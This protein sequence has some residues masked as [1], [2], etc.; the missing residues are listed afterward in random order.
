M[1][2]AFENSDVCVVMVA[3]DEFKKEEFMIKCSEKM[4]H[5]RLFDTRNMINAEKARNY[6]I[7]VRKLGKAF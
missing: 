2:K 7:E 1:E 6:G 5:P 3:H 4:K